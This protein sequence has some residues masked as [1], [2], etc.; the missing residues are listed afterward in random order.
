MPGSTF[1]VYVLPISGGEF[2]SQLAMLSEMYDATILANDGFPGESQI[3]PDLVLGASGG[4]ISAYVGLGADWSSSGIIRICRMVE[5]DMFIKS[6]WPDALN[7]LPTWILGLF[8]QSL[9]RAGYGIQPLFETIFT[10]ETVT[11]TSVMTLTFNETK[12]NPQIF[13][14][15]SEEQS[16]IKN[17]MFREEDEISYDVSSITFNDGNIE[18]ISDATTASYSIPLVTQLQSID[19]EQHADGG[20][21][22][23]SPFTP[24][25]LKIVQNYPP[26]PERKLQLIHFSSYNM[27]D[28]EVDRTSFYGDGKLAKSFSQLMHCSILQDRSLLFQVL[29]LCGLQLT[30]ERGYKINTPDLA[31]LLNRI[32]DK[33]FALILYP[34][35]APHIDIFD[36]KPEDII[37]CINQARIDYNYFLWI[38]SE[39]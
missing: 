32:R 2:P 1:R 13:C 26:T 30:E 19:G 8:T 18:K 33:N 11:R 35:G 24:L 31:V 29:Q 39:G 12:G 20:I 28:P 15:Q 25:H 5:Q 27:N 34:S 16:P 37:N 4:N 14:N 23:A 10:P 3:Q 17:S 38:E 9:Y 21:N 6:W 36:F 22:Y 7:F